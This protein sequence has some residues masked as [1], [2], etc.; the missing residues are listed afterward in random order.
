MY[1]GQGEGIVTQR[2]DRGGGCS[3]TGRTGRRM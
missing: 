1:E 3:D 2:K